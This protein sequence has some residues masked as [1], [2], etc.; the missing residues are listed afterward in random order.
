MKFLE[1]LLLSSLPIASQMCLMGTD[2]ETV[3]KVQAMSLKIANI[4]ADTVCSIDPF[5]VDTTQNTF[6]RP[7]PPPPDPRDPMRPAAIESVVPI[8]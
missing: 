5:S 8:A 4:S 6:I 3:F 1:L 2:Q 7:F